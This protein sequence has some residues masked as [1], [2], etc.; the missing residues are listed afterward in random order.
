MNHLSQRLDAIRA[1]LAADDIDALIVSSPLNARYLSGFT[2]EGHIVIGKSDTV[3]CTDGRYRVEAAEAQGCDAVFHPK[4]H[5]AGAIDCVTRFGAGVVAFEAEHVTYSDYE[6]MAARLAEIPL[7]PA[8]GWIEELRL[9]KDEDEISAMREA[10]RRADLALERFT[11]DLQ[12]GQTEKA[13]AWKLDTLLM[14]LD[15]EPSFN[16]IMASGPSAAKPHAVPGSRVLTEGDMLKIDMGAKVDG[17]CSDITRTYFLGEPD[18]KIIEVY[19]IVKIAQAAAVAAVRPGA[20]GKELDAIARNIITAG[21]YGEYFGHGLGHGV[22]LAVHEGPRVSSRS[23]DV[24]KPGMVVTIE[25][26]I[27]LEDWGGVRIEDMVVVTETGC[28][29]LTLAPKADYV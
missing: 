27:Y 10:A 1:K 29:V 17:Y 7:H 15:S 22:G 23:E 26:G 14:E 4:G 11:N 3:I 21:G 12:V 20:T 28:E 6:E 8:K 9:I 19:N 24:L 18:E 13:L 16:T 25:P 2:G 5:L